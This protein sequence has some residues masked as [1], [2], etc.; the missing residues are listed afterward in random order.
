[1][2]DRTKQCQNKTDLGAASALPK[3]ATCTVNN[4][5]CFDSSVTELQEGLN[6]YPKV[7][8]SGEERKKKVGKKFAKQ[9]IR[10][11]HAKL[12]LLVEIDERVAASNNQES[13]F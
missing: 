10:N 1:M 13:F 6:E 5:K 12:T 11:P 4:D 8:I 9:T 7:L 3:S 2:F